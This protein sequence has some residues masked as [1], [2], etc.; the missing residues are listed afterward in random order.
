MTAPIVKWAG[1]KRRLLPE[2][3]KRVPETF[4]T[5]FEPFAGGAA[6]FF[7]LAPERAVLCDA[8][9]ALMRVYAAVAVFTDEVCR[10]LEW[11]RPR[12]DE[13][14]YFIERDRWNKYRGALDPAQE[15]A[16]FLYLNRT[17]FNGL[18]R[19]NKRGEFN[20]PMGAYRD[21]LA[22]YV[23]KVRAAAAVLAR[24]DVRAGDYWTHVTRAVAGDFAYFD[25]PYDGT[26]TAYTP[27]GFSEDDQV[28]LRDAARCLADR[29]VRVLLSNADTPLIREIYAGWKIET[30]RCGRAISADA[31]GRGAVDEVLI[32]PGE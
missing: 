17:C 18:W 5:Y 30:V 3:R 10:L 14:H 1:G 8:N 15:A 32:S 29:G 9:E 11:Y 20:V 31:G 13:E 4:G 7:A 24:A 28:T 2:L 12:H 27:D 6:L 26:F 16:L 25:P 22:G 23:E 21:P 19:V